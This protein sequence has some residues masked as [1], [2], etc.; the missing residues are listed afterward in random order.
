MS[1]R[2]RLRGA[3]RGV[4][5]GASNPGVTIA[6]LVGKVLVLV[7]LAFLILYSISTDIILLGIL[8]AFA[9]GLV[10]R[11]LLPTERF[12][13]FVRG[14]WSGETT[15]GAYEDGRSKLK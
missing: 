8:A 4:E 12:Q 2:K 3:R 14:L 11:A 5:S 6:K 13:N 15:R 1:L 9:V 7:L 10:L